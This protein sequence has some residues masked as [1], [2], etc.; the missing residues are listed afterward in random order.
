MLAVLYSINMDS[1]SFE[2]DLIPSEINGFCD[3]QTVSIHHKN[4]RLVP[5][6][7]PAHLACG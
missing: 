2:V 4:Q 3:S 7:M 1:S 5:V 6:P